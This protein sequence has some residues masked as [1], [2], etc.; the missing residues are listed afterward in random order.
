[1]LQGIKILDFTHRLPGPLAGKILADMGA[2]VIKVEDIKHKDPFLS[3]MFSEFDQSFENWYEELNKNK[4]V[5]RLDFKSPEIKS[6]IKKLLNGTTGLMLSLSPKLKTSL[7]LDDADLKHLPLAVVELEASSTH[8]KAMHDLNALAISGYL[9]LHVAHENDPIVAPPFMPVAGIA[10]GQQVA[11]QLLANI[12]EANRQKAFVK[13]ISYLHDTAE[14]I[15]HPFWSKTLRDQKKTKFLHNGAYPC[16]S[17][18]RTSDGQYVAVAAVEEKF[19][20]DLILT[21]SIDLPLERR[22]ETTSEAFNAVARVFA[23]LDASEVETKAQNKELCLSI[24]RK[25]S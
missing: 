15:L 4:K 1:M 23:K 14:S 25:I 18:Y 10:F 22:F 7:G 5:I 24:V 2:E 9:S 3:G 20:S 6:E 16:Y 12:I 17:L 11:T 19:W 13:S 8:N 21:F